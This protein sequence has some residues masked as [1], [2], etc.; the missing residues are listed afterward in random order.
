[1]TVIAR[2]ATR[3][4]L[5]TFLLS[6][7]FVLVAVLTGAGLW[8]AL[9]SFTVLGGLALVLA[10]YPAGIAV[11][12]RVF[13]DGKIRLGRF[14]EF[15]AVT[16]S[17][18][19]VLL[20]LVGWVGPSIARS[21][22]PNVPDGDYNRIANTLS[23]AELRS[24]AAAAVARAES[25]S[26]HVSV[27]TWRPANVLVW[28]YVR[29]LAGVAQPV[30]FAWLGLLAGFWAPRIG[31]RDLTQ[32]QY[33]ALGLFLV[34]STYLAGENSYELVAIQS[35]GPAFFSGWMVLIVPTV[36]LLGVGWP[37]LMAVWSRRERVSDLSG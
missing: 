16:A 34:V 17:L 8:E 26:E 21:I 37:T 32:A 1:M 7:F 27:E 29:R 11:S 22:D 23:L 31:R 10:A 33:W 35:A 15:V 30:L 3:L 25:D 13:D 9:T 4:L 12:Q 5:W 28:H 14:A 2:F 19:V 24:T 36:L 18:A 20:V 6:S